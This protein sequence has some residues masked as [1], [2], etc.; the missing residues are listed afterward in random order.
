MFVTVR[1]N[2][3]GEDE[4]LEFCG[5]TY[6]EVCKGKLRVVVTSEK[7]VYMWYQN[8]IVKR[9]RCIN[10]LNPWTNNCATF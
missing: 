3:F 10:C 1:E 2:V 8:L 4:V 5:E 9:L 6:S 7:P